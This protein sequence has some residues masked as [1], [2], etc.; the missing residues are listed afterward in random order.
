MIEPNVRRLAS[1]AKVALAGTVLALCASCAPAQSSASPV[2][3]FGGEGARLSEPKQIPLEKAPPETSTGPCQAGAPPADRALIDD[4]EDGDNKIF[5]AFQREGWLYVAADDTPGESFPPVGTLK[6]TELP[7]DSALSDQRF[8]LHGTGS[9]HSAWG[10][11]WGMTLRW[12]G[13]GSK[14]P[15]N[16]SGF[17]GLRFRA[18]GKGSLTVRLGTWDT[19]PGEYEG[20][21]K[22]RCWDEHGKRVFLS[23]SWQVYTV[24]WDQLQQ[25]GWGAEARFD[26]KHV[27]HLNFAAGPKDLPIDFWL[28]DLE[29]LSAEQVANPHTG[30]P[31]AH[32]EPSTPPDGSTRV[33]M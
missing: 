15:L 24:L 13:E 27:L 7:A 31:G 21:C 3:V 18:K 28:D 6:P 12:V 1:C 23:D 5:K 10:V 2:A 9:G 17:E 4:F 32:A 25:E 20:K 19:V 11:I 22:N 26:P 29:F 16:V 8:A 33:G 14:C 30:E